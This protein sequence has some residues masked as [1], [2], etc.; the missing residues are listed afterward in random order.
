MAE[1]STKTSTKIAASLPIDAGVGLKHGFKEISTSDLPKGE[2]N[3]YAKLRRARS[4]ARF[5]GARAKREKEKADAEDA[6]KK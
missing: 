4:D 3:A 6:K 1:D 5:V 2:E